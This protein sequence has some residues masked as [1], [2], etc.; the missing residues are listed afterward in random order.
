MAALTFPRGLSA[1]DPS[2]FEFTARTL[3]KQKCVNVTFWRNLEY[4]GDTRNVMG[5]TLRV[6]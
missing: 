5:L 2:A 4:P 1:F 6:L 3:R